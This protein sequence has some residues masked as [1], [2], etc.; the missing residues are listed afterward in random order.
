[1]YRPIG[2]SYQTHL[3]IHARLARD[4]VGRHRRNVATGCEPS[5]G[6]RRTPG[7]A[8]WLTLEEAR[9]RTPVNWLVRTAGQAFGAL[10]VVGLAMA[11]IGLYGMKAYLVAQRTREIGIRMALG[12]T[13]GGVVSLVM[14]DGIRMLVAGLAVG[15][16][17]AVGA[18]PPGEPTRR[19]REPAGPARPRGCD[20]R[21]RRGRD[22]R[23]LSAGHA[24][25]A[26][27]TGAG[28]PQRVTG[29]L[30]LA[31]GAALSNATYDVRQWAC[32]SPARGAPGSLHPVVVADDDS[33][34][35]VMPLLSRR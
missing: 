27:R 11:V 8:D 3:N 20:D 5:A 17:L 29:W 28:V 15:F 24:R 16:V 13:P 14:K 19:G 32:R 33:V 4:G 12:A 26:N 1:M 2:E 18:G 23:E 10:G 31:A 21:D 22:S 30:C 34:Y 25:D 6:Y 7:P 35:C 9:D